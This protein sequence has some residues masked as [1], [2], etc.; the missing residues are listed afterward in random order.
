MTVAVRA[1]ANNAA[2]GNVLREVAKGLGQPVLIESIRSADDWFSEAVV[3]PRRQAALL[4][5]IAAL[6]LTLALAGVFGITAY[7]VGRRQGEIGIRLALGARRGQVFTK[8][9]GEAVLPIAVGT[10]IGLAS[11]G[12]TAR[13]MQ[14]FLF[15]TSP[16][17]A[18]TL[19]VVGIAFL[20]S[21]CL[22][23]FVPVYLAARVDPASS[24][25]G[26]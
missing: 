11:T 17:D 20:M 22:A 7:V 1:A 15:R 13:L 19:A 25:R 23:A 18:L 8:I 14:S 24:L 4:G 3:T 9:L 6:G 2:I 16:A 26:Q 5:T 21:G 12:L 10:T